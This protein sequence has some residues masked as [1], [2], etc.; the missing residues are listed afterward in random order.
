M[1][2]LP[3]PTSITTT[4]ERGHRATFTIEPLYPGYGMT[5]GNALRR[6]L[7]SSLPGAAITAV[8][9]AGVSHEFSTLPYVKEDVVDILL[10]LK[11]IRLKL[12]TDEP[13]TIRIEAQGTGDVTAGDIAA[14]ADVDIVNPKQHIATLTDQAAKLSMELT[15]GPGRGYVPVENREK[16]RLPLGTI[17][18]DAIYTPMKNV[19]F[20]TENVRVG[21]MTNYDKL[22]LEITTDGT[23]TPPDALEQATK[24]L[25]DHFQFVLDH[26]HGTAAPADQEQP[27]PVATTDAAEEPKKKTR[28]K[29]AE[30]PKGE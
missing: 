28:K 22:N 3:L 12:H 11:L 18:L 10:N 4:S 27:D 16:E 29:K 24:I 23:I 8:N 19:N 25:V 14:N 26:T 1:E 5:V 7:L 15:V 6:V 13:T 30:E 20:T 17:A 2:S 9:I 21:Q